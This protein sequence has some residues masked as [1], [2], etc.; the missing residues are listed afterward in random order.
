VAGGKPWSG[1][2]PYAALRAGHRGVRRY[3]RL[4]GESEIAV[5]VGN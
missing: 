2:R 3:R 4:R 5:V 1:C